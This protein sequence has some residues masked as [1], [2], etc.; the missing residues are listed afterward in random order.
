MNKI[1]ISFILTFVILSMVMGIWDGNAG[2]AVTTALSPLSTVSTI[3]I[4]DNTTGFETSGIIIMNNEKMSYASKDV[5]HF[6]TLGRGAEGTTASIHAV[7]EQVYNENAGV[8]N[9]ALG[10]NPT[11]IASANGFFALVLI[12]W[13]FFTITLPRSMMWDFSLFQ[14][15]LLLYVRVILMTIS[16]CFYIVFAVQLGSNAAYMFKK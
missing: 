15:G 6:Y 12:P 2:I 8:V 11:A 10:F 13:S 9:L 5:T 1:V 3:A 4:V 16:I 7:G 14:S